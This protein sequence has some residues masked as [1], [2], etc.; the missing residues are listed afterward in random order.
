[1]GATL[2]GMFAFCTRCGSGVAPYRGREWNG[3]FADDYDAPVATADR[4]D[5]RP[6]D[7]WCPPC[8]A[9]WRALDTMET[10]FDRTC[11]HF[12]PCNVRYCGVCGRGE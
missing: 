2:Q 12:M 10:G 6:T 8:R 7:Y 9:V 3:D 1:M 4:D 11:G 5:K